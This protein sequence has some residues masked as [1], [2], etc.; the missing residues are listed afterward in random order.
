M[1]IQ[2]DVVYMWTLLAYFVYTFITR[3]CIYSPAR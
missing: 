2:L 1:R 3:C